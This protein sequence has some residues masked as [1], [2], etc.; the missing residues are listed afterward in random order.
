MFGGAGHLCRRHTP[1]HQH[2]AI[3]EMGLRPPPSKNLTPLQSNAH[4]PQELPARKRTYTK[5][6][7]DVCLEYIY[8]KHKTRKG[9][10]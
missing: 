9:K 8:M 2:K 6:Y 1:L 7:K 5:M 4:F 10:F 3:R